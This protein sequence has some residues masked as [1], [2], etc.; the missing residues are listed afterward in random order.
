MLKELV[1]KEKI[2]FLAIQET[3]LE[4]VSDA[5]CYSIWGSE[6][7]HWYFLPDVGNSGGILSIWCKSSS[8]LIFNFSGEVLLEFVWNGVFTIKYVSLLTYIQ[9]VTLRGR[10]GYGRLF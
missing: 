4:S 8:S 1:R 7:C 3:K 10:G 5:L 6:D 2:D 9:S